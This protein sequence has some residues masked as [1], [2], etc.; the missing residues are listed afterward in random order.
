MSQSRKG[1]AHARDDGANSA[2]DAS[3]KAT[4]LTQQS[5]A[6]RLRCSRKAHFPIDFLSADYIQIRI[7]T[8]RICF[9]PLLTSSSIRVT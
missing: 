8:D 9:V 6:L 7:A 1:G 4:T 3:S 5:H 2:Q